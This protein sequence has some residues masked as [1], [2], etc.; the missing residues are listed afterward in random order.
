MY[1]RMIIMAAAGLWSSAAVAQDNSCVKRESVV[2]GEIHKTVQPGGF[3]RWLEIE[4]E[5]AP[6][7]ISNRPFQGDFGDSDHTEIGLTATVR[8]CLSDR[9]GVKAWGGPTATLDD[10]GDSEAEAEAKL[11]VELRWFSGFGRLVPLVAFHTKARFE[12]AFKK[13]EGR[14]QFVEAGASLNDDLHTNEVYGLKPMVK[15][16]VVL[17]WADA[18]RALHGDYK[19][20]FAA[21]QVHVPIVR[22]KLMISVEAIGELRRHGKVDPALGRKRREEDALLFVGLDVAGFIRSALRLPFVKQVRLG[23][24]W[25]SKWSNMEKTGPTLRIRPGLTLGL[26]FE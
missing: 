1:S 12:G 3:P 20:A 23:L 24:V 4:G 16:R 17:R 8:H 13:F 18:D 7:Y 9:F 11:A 10:D 5:I 14:Q 6:D 19:G 26:P 22:E 25:D 21:L 2:P 15:G